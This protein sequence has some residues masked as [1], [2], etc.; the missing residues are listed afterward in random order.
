[1]PAVQVGHIGCSPIQIVGRIFLVRYPNRSVV[2]YVVLLM[3][4]RELVSLPKVGDA[5][6]EL[7]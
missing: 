2:Q 4:F 3:L 7:F 1:M 6:N 5:V